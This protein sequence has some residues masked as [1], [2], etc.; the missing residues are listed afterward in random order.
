M[1]VLV[2]GGGIGGLACGVALR[3]VGHEPVVLEQAPKL[4]FV[5]Q[6]IN[7]GASATKALRFIG[8][9]DEVHAR[10]TETVGWAFHG[11][12]DGSLQLQIPLGDRFGNERYISTHRADLLGAIV[13]QL[14]PDD[15]RLNSTIVEVGDDDGGVWARMADGTRVNG[16]LMVGADGVKSLVRDSFISREDAIFSRFVAWRAAVPSTAAP[17]TAERREL[18]MFSGN[19]K[20]LV[21]YPIRDNLVNLSAYELTNEAEAESWS[22]GGDINHLRS[23]FAEGCDEVQQALNSLETAL[24]TGIYVRDPLERWVTDRVALIGDAAHAMGPFSGNGGG[25]ALED[26]VTLAL[27]LEGITTPASAAA[28][29]QEYELRRMP[30]MHHLQ[31]DARVRLSALNDPDPRAPAIRAGIWAGSTRLDPQSDLEF[32]WLYE[33]DPVEAAR[34]PI[35]ELDL[36]GTPTM[37]RREAQR[38]ADLWAGALTFRDHAAGWRG[39]RDGYDRFL[40]ETFPAPVD[41][42]VNGAVFGGVSCLVV[43]NDETSDLERVVLHLHGGGYVRGSAAGAVELAARIGDATRATVVVPDYRLAPEH[44]FP[45]APVDVLAT[46]RALLEPYPHRSIVVTGDDAGAGLALGLCVALR[47]AGE[48][49][50]AAL[51]LVSPFADLTVSSNSLL[52]TTSSRD[53]FMTRQ[54]ATLC[55][56]CYIQTADPLLSAVSP[57]RADLHGLPPMLIAA[58]RH[59]SFSDDAVA[60]HEA[61]DDATLMLVDDSVHS[62]VLFDFLPETHE[63][64]QRLAQLVDKTSTKRPVGGTR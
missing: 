57:V 37:V 23:V 29:L 11:L 14:N 21:L 46:Y 62:F 58:A 43:G 5:G 49:L 15:I 3:K 59:E 34:T 54:L 32:S 63:A 47:D 38:A 56:A 10:G 20:F 7:L 45:A 17:I 25:A 31:I 55:A 40:H 1:R 48:S 9:S 61:A 2:A 42:P 24:V 13:E 36:A 12:T 64:M 28:A 27:C 50:P 39:Q 33:H 8:A 41:L 35:D 60:V 19:A 18:R 53:P 16:D 52:A 26:A 6:G 22:R 4:G 30:R 51:L 44:P